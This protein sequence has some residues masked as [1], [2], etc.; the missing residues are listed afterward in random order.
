MSIYV[1]KDIPKTKP[2]KSILG[3]HICKFHHASKTKGKGAIF[4]VFS[5]PKSIN[6]VIVELIGLLGPTYGV[7]D[8]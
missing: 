1:K 8:T 3:L 5:G 6:C 2:K 7:L 4:G